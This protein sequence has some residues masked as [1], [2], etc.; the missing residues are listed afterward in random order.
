MIHLETPS[1]EHRPDYLQALEEFQREGRRLEI[2]L[3]ALERGFEHYLRQ[4][5]DEAS[6]KDPRDGRVPQTTFWG[7]DEADGLFAGEVRLR[8]RLNERLLLEGGHI[9]YEVRPSRRLQGIGTALLRLALPKARE[10][11]IERALVT[12]DEDNAG[13]RKIIETC[14]GL[15]EDSVEAWD[16]MMKRRYW[17]GLPAA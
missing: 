6:G 12:C 17:I 2:D 4:L 13:S 9:G 15:L 5:A 10:L 11:G 7:I 3:R 14:G 1:L 16:G 8:H